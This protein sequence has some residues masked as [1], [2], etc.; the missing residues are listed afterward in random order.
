MSLR[1]LFGTLCAGL[2][3]QLLLPGDQPTGI[4]AIGLLSA[5]AWT[6]IGLARPPIGRQMAEG[7]LAAH[8]LL[9]L[10]ALSILGTILPQNRSEAFYGERLGR[11][12][13]VLRALGMTDLF[14]SAAFAALLGLL[15]ATIVIACWR[16]RAL[17]VRYLA[18]AG[19]HLGC[20]LIL[21]GAA[22]SFATAEH[23]RLDLRVGEPAVSM[24]ERTRA[25][26]ATGDFVS[27]GVEVRL[28]SFEVERAD[29]RPILAR[30]RQMA[31]GDWKYLEGLE[32][33][34]GQGGQ[35]AG[36]IRV[37]VIELFP[38]LVFEEEVSAADEGPGALLVAFDGRQR[39]LVE[40]APCLSLTADAEA[41][42]PTS[43]RGAGEA[44]RPIASSAEI[45]FGAVETSPG[46]STAA[47]L[48]ARDD[49]RALS[50]MTSKTGA[51]SY[52]ADLGDPNH[53]AHVMR[54]MMKPRPEVEMTVDPARGLVRLQARGEVD[55]HPL[56]EGSTFLGI[57]LRRFLAAAEYRR[58]PTTR[59][60]AMRHP[61][62]LIAIDEG[63]R[64][65]QALL[66]AS[67]RDAVRLANGDALTL[68]MRGADI[69]A[70]QSRLEIS[71]R[72]GSH[73]LALLKVNQPVDLDGWKLYQARFDPGDADFAGLEAVRDRGTPIA[74]VGFFLLIAGLLPLT[75]WSSRSGAPRTA[76]G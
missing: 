44:A 60:G 47:V 18:F 63:E 19:A 35:L 25:G 16:R 37:E 32:A 57:S 17:T 52:S 7:T 29:Q 73:R 11:M 40:G 36:D 27:L 66:V 51:L 31:D 38:D 48:P 75:L 28:L 45:C 64:R 23:A 41:G 76:G 1:I 5:A 2:S 61:A 56:E 4:L 69:T 21:A 49:D 68:Q 62:A 24:A 58:I 34:T 42:A 59:S 43:R 74:F 8:V 67:S 15:A 39:W 53:H 3:A 26:R 71:E 9:A 70:F 6:S 33:Q 54:S 46:D 30:Y 65:D 55:V 72:D 13:H 12:A 14:H 22:T 20:L 50:R 10:G